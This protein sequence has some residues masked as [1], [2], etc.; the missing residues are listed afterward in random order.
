MRRRIDNLRL[1]TVTSHGSHVTRSEVHPRESRT[2][3]A[4]W[5]AARHKPT[6]IA[7]HHNTRDTVG[8]GSRKSAP[9]LCLI[10]RESARKTAVP[11]SVSQICRAYRSVQRDARMCFSASVKA[12]PVDCQPNS[13]ATSKAVASTRRTLRTRGATA[14]IARRVRP[15]EISVVGDEYPCNGGSY[16]PPFRS[17]ASSVTVDGNVKRNAHVHTYMRT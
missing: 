4:R 7:W 1:A 11:L 10:V 5:S 16:P 6:G 15:P 14:P 13:K 8:W 17:R 12:R 3:Q 9:R 2:S